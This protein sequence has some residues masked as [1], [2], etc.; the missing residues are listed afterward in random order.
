MTEA[1]GNM[2]ILLGHV[3]Q[4]RQPTHTSM[5]LALVI[6]GSLKNS[7][8]SL[9][10]H[11]SSTGYCQAKGKYTQRYPLST[12]TRKDFNFTAVQQRQKS[13]AE[14]AHGSYLLLVN[15]LQNGLDAAVL[16]DQLQ[17]THRPNAADG[18]TVVAAQQDAKV[19]KLYTVNARCQCQHDYFVINFIS[20]ARGL[21]VG[22]Q[23]DQILPMTSMQH[24]RV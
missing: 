18:T 4:S 11:P 9:Y 3:W 15:V 19:D 5:S 22:F 14:R 12:R 13:H 10:F 8:A 21:K 17:R 1:S 2:L 24:T 6:S 7:R 16:L 23:Y 20:A